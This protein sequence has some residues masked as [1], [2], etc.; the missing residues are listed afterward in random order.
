[1]L[2]GLDGLDPAAA[3]RASGQRYLEMLVDEGGDGP[4][5]AGVP[6]G[7]TGSL[8][9]V[10]GDFP[11]V[12]AAERRGLP[13]GLALGVVEL[14]AQG[15]AFGDQLGDPPFEGGDDGAEGEDL[16]LE[17]IDQGKSF[18]QVLYARG[19]GPPSKVDMTAPITGQV[20]K[21]NYLPR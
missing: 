19:H 15:L 7:S 16:L 20:A 6:L 4:V 21:V 3:T 18:R 9:A 5:D 14:V 12:A 10:F 13:S 17:S 1:L 8:P 2:D 11:G